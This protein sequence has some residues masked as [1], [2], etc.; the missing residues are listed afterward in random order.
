VDL[1]TYT[2]GPALFEYLPADFSSSAGYHT[3]NQ[4]VEIEV[5]ATRHI[6]VA[7]LLATGSSVFGR[8][9]ATG[10]LDTLQ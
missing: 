7:L 9:A 10:T 4:P 5:V 1:R 8:C 2:N 6:H 3:I